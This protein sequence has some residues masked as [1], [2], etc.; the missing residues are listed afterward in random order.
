MFESIN[1][2]TLIWLQ[3]AEGCQDHRFVVHAIAIAACASFVEKEKQREKWRE[4][5][6]ENIDLRE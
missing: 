2:L 3:G 4:R 1:R 6:C 5:G